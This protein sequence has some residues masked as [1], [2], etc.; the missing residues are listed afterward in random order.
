LTVLSLLVFLVP[1]LLL[2]SIPGAFQIVQL[3]FT[4]IQPPKP[5][6]LVTLNVPHAI[7][8]LVLLV[9]QDT[10][11][12]QPTPNVFWHVLIL[13]LQTLF[14]SYVNPVMIHA[15][16]VLANLNNNVLHVKMEISFSEKLVLEHAQT[17]SM[18]T[19]LIIRVKYALLLVPLAQ[20]PQHV[21]LVHPL[22]FSLTLNVFLPAPPHIMQTPLKENV[23]LVTLTVPPAP[24]PITG[25]VFLVLP[26]NS[27]LNPKKY[28]SLN[29]L[30]NT[31][32]PKTM[33]VLL[34]Q[35]HAKLVM[36][37]QQPVL[38]ADKDFSIPILVLLHAQQDFMLIL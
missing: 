22:Y 38:L 35:D 27:S 3:A 15:H 20:P 16:L 30:P 4:L 17:N 12:I 24:D 6:M 32:S 33:S 5:V 18:L 34:V 11:L 7:Y 13:L 28:A 14:H 1:N 19:K 8:K 21:P 29:A 25:T 10:S 23:S 36:D 31:T 2:Y 9:F 26:P 37:P